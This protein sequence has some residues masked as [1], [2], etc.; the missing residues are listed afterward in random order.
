MSA[1]FFSLLSILCSVVSGFVSPPGALSALLRYSPSRLPWV[2][3]VQLK[4]CDQ[5]FVLKNVF[6]GA[7]LR[8]LKSVPESS[9]TMAAFMEKV[10][11]EPL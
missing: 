1:L 5:A 2:F 4:Y 8:V 9:K 11:Y 6:V 7:V 3:R 10:G